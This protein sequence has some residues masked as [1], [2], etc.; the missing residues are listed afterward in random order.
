MQQQWTVQQQLKHDTLPQL[1]LEPPEQFQ[2]SSWSIP[3][4][5]DTW[6][7]SQAA[8]SLIFISLFVEQLVM[9]DHEEDVAV[10]ERKVA[11]DR[12]AIQKKTFTKW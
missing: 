8:L 7:C 9:G 11:V 2:K 5:E 3:F 10:D 4:R 1:T 12:D 6:G